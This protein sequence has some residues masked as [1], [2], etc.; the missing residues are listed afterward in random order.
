MTEPDDPIA[1]H[2]HEQL[3]VPLLE[4]AIQIELG[5]GRLGRATLVAAFARIFSGTHIDGEDVWTRKVDLVEFVNPSRQA[6]LIDGDLYHL[7]P[8]AIDV[9]PGALR[10]VV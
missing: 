3:L 7:T 4:D 2:G 5:A 6:V 9:L 1:T 8:V 10:L